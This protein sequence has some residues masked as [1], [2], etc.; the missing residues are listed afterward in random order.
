MWGPSF[1]P[2]AGYEKYGHYD[3]LGTT[4]STDRRTDEIEASVPV[5]SRFAQCMMG[6]GS[7]LARFECAPQRSFSPE[8]PA[9][10][11]DWLLCTSEKY[12]HIVRLEF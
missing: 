1:I 2:E 11:S 10:T 6:Q 4:L 12:F 3:K 9:K 5:I 8:L 7:H